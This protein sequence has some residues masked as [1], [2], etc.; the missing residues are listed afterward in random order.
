MSTIIESAI[1]E[2]TAAPA[3]AQPIADAPKEV[4]PTEQPIE[5]APTEEAP[6]AEDVVFPKKAVNAISR[7]DKQIGK[8]QQER[9][10]LRQELAKVQQK[11][12]EQTKPA[13]M[14][15]EPEPNDFGIPVPKMS[16]YDTFMAYSRAVNKY[17][18]EVERAALAKESE[19]TQRITESQ[20]WEAERRNYQD[21]K[22][23]EFVKANPAAVQVL[24][25]YS[26]V[27]K[28]FSPEIVTALLETD[29][30]VQVLYNLASNGKLEALASMSPARAAIEIG[31]AEAQSPPPKQ[32]TKAPTPM[33]PVKGMATGGKS[34]S[35]YT[36]EEAHA[37]LSKRN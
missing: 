3:E 10:F 36:P 23:D 32:Q 6:Q 33:S 27:I 34:F 20:K 2:A 35:Q 24:K 19:T 13:T 16:D 4:A 26:D 8:L 1:A 7:R 14:G 31:R 11:P 12:A 18:R 9:D 25:E 17:D 30:A 28:E 29:N 21:E 37:F 5:E 22:A 15:D